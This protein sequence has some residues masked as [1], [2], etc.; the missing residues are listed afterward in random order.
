[1]KDFIRVSAFCCMVALC[2]NAK[3][4][5]TLS[6]ADGSVSAAAEAAIP[7]RSIEY[8]DDGITVA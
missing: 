3:A 8:A 5:F 1:M 7:E 6:L 4:Q 2:A